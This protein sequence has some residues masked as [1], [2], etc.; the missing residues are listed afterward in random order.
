MISASRGLFCVRHDRAYELGIL[1]MQVNRAATINVE[2]LQVRSFTLL[3][4]IAE[5]T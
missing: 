2:V 5:L 3:L 4:R 1:E